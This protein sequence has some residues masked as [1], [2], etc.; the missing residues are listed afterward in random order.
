[1]ALAS[2]RLVVE[3]A[4][5]RSLPQ[6]LRSCR[7]PTN[8][9][10]V[11]ADASSPSHRRDSVCQPSPRERLAGEITIDEF[12]CTLK[13]ADRKNSESNR[14]NTPYQPEA[15]PDPTPLGELSLKP[16]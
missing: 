12:Y 5:L 7:S 9:T 1:M 6:A 3:L 11:S 14:G 4:R 8:P 16:R 13:R 15:S 2:S 10:G